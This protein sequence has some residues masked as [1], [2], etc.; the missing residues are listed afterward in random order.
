MV[1]PHSILT[2][3][4]NKLTG[5]ITVFQSSQ[6]SFSLWS[7]NVNSNMPAGPHTFQKSLKP[8]CHMQLKQNRP[9]FIVPHVTVIGTLARTDGIFDTD[10]EIIMSF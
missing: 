3:S 9:F 5:P 6:V 7:V 4:D 1:I 2:W 8:C 10:D